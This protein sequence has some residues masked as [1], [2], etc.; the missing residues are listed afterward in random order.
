MAQLI[1]K[2]A[3]AQLA[4]LRTKAETSAAIVKQFG[5]R[6]HI[7]RGQRIYSD[8]KA[9]ADTVIAGL[10]VALSVEGQAGKTVEPAGK[11][12]AHRNQPRPAA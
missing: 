3:V 9:E 4:G 1:W 8:A 7:T 11:G 6:R 10:I 5:G 12:R 2:D